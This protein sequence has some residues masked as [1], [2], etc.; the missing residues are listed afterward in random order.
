MI[1]Q[2]WLRTA[3]SADGGAVGSSTVRLQYGYDRSGNVL[4][5]R[6]LVN[7]ALSELYQY[8]Q[9]DRLV[10]MKRGVLNAASDAIAAP[11]FQ[12]DWVLDARGNQLGVT[13]DGVAV[14]NQFNAANETTSTTGGSTP[15]YDEAGNTTSRGGRTFVY[16]AWNRLKRVVDGATTIAAYAYD[17]LRRRIVETSNGQTAHVYFDGGVKAVEERVGGG[18]FAYHYV[19]GL[20]G[21]VILRDVYPDV[22]TSPN[23]DW[24]TFAQTDA[25]GNVVALVGAGTSSGN[26]EERNVYA[27]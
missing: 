12:Q 11:T 25:N 16:D 27:P 19:T 8:D 6:D 15:G 4:Y 2:N 18:G 9:L 14:A 22:S 1:D 3:G 13:T 24:R 10:A 17:A 20:T 26:V 23:A 5:R 21:Q 7:A